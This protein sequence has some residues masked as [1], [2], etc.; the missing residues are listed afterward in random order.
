MTKWWR[1]RGGG[2]LKTLKDINPCLLSQYLCCDSLKNESRTAGEF[3]KPFVLSSSKYKTVYKFSYL[4]SPFDCSPELAEGV[5]LRAN[6]ILSPGVL[7]S[8][9][10]KALC[11]FVLPPTE[12]RLRGNDDGV[13]CDL[14]KMCKKIKAHIG[15]LTDN[16]PYSNQAI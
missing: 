6:G 11:Y 3:I 5:A 13:A 7:L 14:I 16:C 12:M 15:A 1:I 2:N 8:L 10:S 9:K 4:L